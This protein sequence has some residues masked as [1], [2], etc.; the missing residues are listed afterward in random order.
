MIKLISLPLYFAPGYVNALFLVKTFVYPL[1]SSLAN[2]MIVPAE[3]AKKIS[4]TTR[5][6]QIPNVGTIARLVEIPA[7][8][9]CTQTRPLSVKDVLQPTCRQDLF[10][11]LCLRRLQRPLSVLTYRQGWPSCLQMTCSP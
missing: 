6:S 3:P 11:G 4:V 7:V 10:P 1:K 5:L 8:S 9:G 2:C